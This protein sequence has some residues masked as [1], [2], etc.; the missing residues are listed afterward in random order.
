MQGIV[1]SIITLR[2]L[3]DSPI[4]GKFVN[5]NSR[6]DVED[7]SMHILPPRTYRYCNVRL[8]ELQD[9]FE[10]PHVFTK[11]RRIVQVLPYAMAVMSFYFPGTTP[12]KAAAY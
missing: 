2:K 12:P 11:V 4:V 8:A 6:N 1:Q 10:S 5:V 3:S 9:L 7:E